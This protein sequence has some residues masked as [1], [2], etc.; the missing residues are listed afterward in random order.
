[1]TVADTDVLIDFLA[2]R[3][4][5]A[6]RVAIELQSG[7]FVTTAITRFEMLAGARDRTSE[8]LLRR[9]LDSMTALPLD[10]DSADRAADVRRRLEAKGEGIGMA[11]SLIV[12]IV[13]SHDGMLL[14]RN[15]RHFERVDGLKLATSKPTSAA[16]GR[17]LSKDRPGRWKRSRLRTPVIQ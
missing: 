9:L 14:T 7:V 15:R 10:R 2:D 8:G 1:L 17:A 5:A 11:D 12:G 4:P 13:L 6:Q 16:L 3:G